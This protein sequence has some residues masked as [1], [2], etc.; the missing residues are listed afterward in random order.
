MGEGDKRSPRASP[1]RTEQHKAGGPERTSKELGAAGTGGDRVAPPAEQDA[2]RMPRTTTLDDPLTT[3]LLAEVARRSRT[4][5]VS[6]D[7]ITEATEIEPA[8]LGVSV[9]A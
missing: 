1:G 6:P 7:Q 5:D 4:I 8:E 2:P 3:S 9:G